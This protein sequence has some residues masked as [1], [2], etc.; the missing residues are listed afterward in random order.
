M[1]LRSFTQFHPLSW[2]EG[3]A[4]NG[5]RRFGSRGGGPSPDPGGFSRGDLYGLK[6][7]KGGKLRMLGG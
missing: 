7:A 1:P 5:R 4:G 3:L 2:G 6:S